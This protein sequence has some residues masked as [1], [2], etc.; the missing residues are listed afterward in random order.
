VAVT[1]PYANHLHIASESRLTDN[2][3]STLSLNF[4]D[5]MLFLTPNQQCQSTEGKLSRI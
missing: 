2:H 5:R 4:I 3:T 1:S